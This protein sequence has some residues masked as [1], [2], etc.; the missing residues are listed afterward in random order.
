MNELDF[1]R[2]PKSFNHRVI[3]AIAAPAHACGDAIVMKRL[4]I[5]YAG[6]L[7][8]TIAVMDEALAGRAIAEGHVEG[9]H[10]QGGCHGRGH[11]P[12]NDPSAEQVDDP[13][14]RTCD[15]SAALHKA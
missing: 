2:V 1:Q 13:E 8:P 5:G 12:A 10:H 6:V 11:F 3:V 15:P 9:R 7:A 14:N 4:A